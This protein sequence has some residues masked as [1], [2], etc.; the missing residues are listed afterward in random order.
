MQEVWLNLLKSQVGNIDQAEVLSMTVNEISDLTLGLPVQSTFI[1]D[2][3]LKDITEPT[4]VSDISFE[5]YL[6]YFRDKVNVLRSFLTEGY[7]QSFF[8][9]GMRYYWIPVEDFP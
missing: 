7:E 8:S 1:K 5:N 9:N 3:K 2:V 4:V 6:D